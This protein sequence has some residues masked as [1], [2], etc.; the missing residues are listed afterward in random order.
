MWRN[1]ALSLGVVLSGC[2]T[3]DPAD[4]CNEYINATAELQAKGQPCNAN[5]DSPSDI[6][7]FCSTLAKCTQEGLLSYQK[8]GECYL[9]LPACV[10]GQKQTWE[11]RL[12]ACAAYG[13][14]REQCPP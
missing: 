6:G 2:A 7:K 8:L 4:V 11:T 12:S 14:T 1:L 5:I 9:D 13:P 10:S 3:V